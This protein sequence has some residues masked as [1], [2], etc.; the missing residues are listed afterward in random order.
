MLLNP[1][2]FLLIHVFIRTFKHFKTVFT[3]SCAEFANAEGDDVQEHF[4]VMIAGI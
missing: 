2:K 3:S 1:V 4:H